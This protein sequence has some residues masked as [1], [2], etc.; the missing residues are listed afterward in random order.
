LLCPFFSSLN[1]LSLLHNLV[2]STDATD[3][4]AFLRAQNKMK[5]MAVAAPVVSKKGSNVFDLLG[6]GDSSDSD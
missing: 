2:Q 3:E 5:E 1:A 6:E 4:A